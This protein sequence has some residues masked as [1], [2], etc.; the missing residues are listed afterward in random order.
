MKMIQFTPSAIYDAIGK[1]NGFTISDKTVEISISKSVEGTYLEDSDLGNTM[2]RLKAIDGKGFVGSVICTYDRVDLAVIGRML[3]GKLA[4]P[5][6]VVTVHAALGHISARYGIVLPTS[7][8]KDA[9]ILWDEDGALF[10]IAAKEDS[11][12][13]IGSATFTST[14]LPKHITDIVTADELPNYDQFRA[15]AGKTFVEFVTYGRDYTEKFDKFVDVTAQN[16]DAQALL[17]DINFNL[18]NDFAYSASSVDRN[19]YGSTFVYNGLNS[20]VE[21][22]NPA[23]KYVMV[24]AMNPDDARYEGNVIIHYNDPA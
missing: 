18:G 12:C 2:V 22:T 8:I 17:A 20:G 16:F 15:Y 5:T 23:Y 4:L 13:W 7:E 1:A 9:E 21:G 19:L 10:E 6:D 11:L 3:G 24:I 14:V